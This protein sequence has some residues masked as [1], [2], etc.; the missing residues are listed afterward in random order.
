MSTNMR[1][2]GIHGANL[3]VKAPS[4]VTPSDFSIGG[5][6][7]I[8]ERKYDQA[9]LVQTFDDFRTIFGK[10][11]STTTY[12]YDAVKGFFDNVSGV[13]A[14]LYVNSYVGYTG[15]AIDA[16]T[17]SQVVNNGDSNPLLT[18]KDAYLNVLGYGVSGNRTGITITN[19]DRFST[20]VATTGTKDDTFALLNS[21]SDI[22]IG[23]TMK[24][25]ATGGGGATV[26]KVITAVDQNLKKVSFSGAFHASANLAA[27]DA[28]TV[29]GIR[30]RVWRLDL[31]GYLTEVDPDLGKTYCSI[32]SAVTQYYITNIFKNSKWIQI[33]RAATTPSTP[34]KDFPADV[35]SPSYPTNGADGTAPTTA[36]HWSHALSNF[37]NLPMRF[38]ANPETS[39]KS[40]QDAIETYCAART[41]D[42]PI[43]I[44]TLPENQSQAQLITLGNNVQRSNEVDAVLVANWLYVD[45]PFDTSVYSPNR[46]I[47]PVG[48]V[49]GA[50]IW[51]IANNGIHVI[52]AVANVTLRGVNDVE[53]DQ[54]VNDD[55]RTL[56]A[57]AG[58]NVIRNIIGQGIRIMNLFTPSTVTA[59]Q[60]ANA[61]LLRN[62]IKISCIESLGGDVNEPNSYDRIKAGK[63]AI[64]N[65]GQA[66]WD[67]G[68]TGSVPA[69]ETFGQYQLPDGSF[70]K[71]EDH[72]QVISDATVNTA[73]TIQAGQRNY[74][75]YFS[76][77]PPASSIVISTGLLQF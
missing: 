52:P 55:N 72:F 11:I 42:N 27:T 13:S 31:T 8:F 25:V 68:S 57:A 1:K 41:D 29:R 30:L 12:G 37:D 21:V 47:P 44:Y 63:M 65:F 10:Q 77:P 9:F 7:G 61:I 4:S 38:I 40:I 23:D 60:Y 45:N 22:N 15:S 28:A 76:A 71:F 46:A 17:A 67:R 5:I 14:K 50:W 62:Y 20:T 34:D 33:T 56:V 39:T 24:F 36:S 2:L 54:L 64:L 35:A 32:S 58:V 53:G 19:G 75:I 43:C 26:Y 66:L 48:H 6:L 51:D 74:Y 49:M 18:I 73:T 69:G 3:P 59:Y 16:V 70:S